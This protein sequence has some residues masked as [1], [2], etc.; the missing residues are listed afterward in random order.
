[1]KP[2]SASNIN[3]AKVILLGL[4]ILL[5]AGIGY[6]VDLTNYVKASEPF[7][8]LQLGFNT[9][10]DTVCYNYVNNTGSYI[11][12]GFSWGGS[13]INGILDHNK[14]T[15]AVHCAGCGTGYVYV[16]YKLPRGATNN[17][18]WE[19]TDSSTISQNYTIPSSCWNYRWQQLDDK[20]ELSSSY[21]KDCS[22]QKSDHGF[23][24]SPG[25]YLL[26]HTFL[27]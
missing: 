18:I 23:C 9:T 1:M 25:F 24:L 15:N 27:K 10:G 20:E 16:N 5:I 3:K 13:G 11:D 14:S 19:I 21:Q 2:A 8:C 22:F 26:N 7:T 6:A 17:S 4:M 12:G